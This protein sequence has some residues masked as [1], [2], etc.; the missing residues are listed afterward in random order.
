MVV[1]AEAL[2][3]WRHPIQGFIPPDV[4]VPIAEQT[5]LLAPMTRQVL[6]RAVVW[7]SAMR[8][9]VPAFC[10]AVNLSPRS[11]LDPD[12]ET[13]V[14]QALAG[15]G[16]DPSALI[17][18]ITEGA[19]M[20]DA[21]RVLPCLHRLRALGIGIAIDDFGTG[22]SSLSYLRTLPATELK[23]DR[24]FLRDVDSQPRARA[25]VEAAVQLGHILGLSVVAE[26]IETEP[27]HEIMGWLR[28]RRWTGLALRTTTARE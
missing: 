28:L 14:T 7:A 2:V 18:E 25:I 12:L 16:L 3:R 21:R 27:V 23:I 4:F 9:R 11:L 22:Q 1:G 15:S 6:G 5:S 26:G 19:V 20:G 17:L 13:M 24:S 10:V 8:R